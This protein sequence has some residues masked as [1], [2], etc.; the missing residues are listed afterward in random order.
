MHD[1]RLLLPHSLSVAL[2]S[3]PHTVK[4]PPNPFQGGHSLQGLSL[5]GPPLPDK[6]T[7]LSFSPSPKT[8]SLHFSSAQRLSFGNSSNNSCSMKCQK[9]GD[10]RRELLGSPG[11]VPA[12][13]W[14]MLQKWA[15]HWIKMGSSRTWSSP[16]PTNTP[17][18]HLH[19]ERFS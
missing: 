19:V 18:I 8:L 16:S 14:K 2:F 13:V 12:W 3:T 5:L 6:A 10:G 1:A 11:T 9:E 7:K 17:K 15:G 4:P